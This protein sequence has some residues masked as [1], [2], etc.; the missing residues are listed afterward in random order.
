MRNSVLMGAGLGALLTLSQGVAV[1]RPRAG[2]SDGAKALLASG[3]MF[4]V[5]ED[6]LA[7]PI[8]A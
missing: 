6:N 7:L 4:L 3:G 2:L 8:N 5:V 1:A